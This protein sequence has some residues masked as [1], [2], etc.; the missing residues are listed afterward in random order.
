MHSVAGAKNDRN[1][2]EYFIFGNKENVNLLNDGR[3]MVNN[4]TLKVKN[5]KLPQYLKI[6]YETISINVNKFNITMITS[7]KKQ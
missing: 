2:I 7:N 4:A 1:T 5:T 3:N 6:K